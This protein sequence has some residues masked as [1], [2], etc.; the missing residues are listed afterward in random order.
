MPEENAGEDDA[1]ASLLLVLVLDDGLLVLAG[2]HGDGVV[3]LEVAM[4]IR[5][6]PVDALPVGGCDPLSADTAVVRCRRL[7]GGGGALLA[8]ERW[9]RGEV[10]A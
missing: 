10:G 3:R 7:K 9:S 5:A 8:D 6:E 4:R 1:P 2:L